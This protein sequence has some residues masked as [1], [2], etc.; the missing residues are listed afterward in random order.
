MFVSILK[1][2]LLFSLP[3]LALSRLRNTMRP[4][5]VTIKAEC[6]VSVTKTTRPLKWWVLFWAMLIATGLALDPSTPLWAI[7]V[8]G[9]AISGYI[10]CADP[11]KPCENEMQAATAHG[12][13]YAVGLF[14]LIVGL[15]RLLGGTLEVYAL[16]NLF[17]LG[18]GAVATLTLVFAE[19][20][21]I[22]VARLAKRIKKLHSTLSGK[23]HR[24]V[25]GH[26]S[27]NEDGEL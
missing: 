15:Y 21:S 6:G 9:L 25:I 14:I 23:L 26:Y 19:E 11:T 1:A 12:I 4:V 2:V 7:G 10:F 24:R 18:C 3:W 22:C 17:G 5:T 16:G 13:G 27:Y 8:A 20:T